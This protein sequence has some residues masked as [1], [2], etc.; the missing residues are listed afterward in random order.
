MA[1]K[2]TVETDVL[3]IGGGMAGCFAAI[4]ARDKGLDVTL[5]DKGYVSRA[6]QTPF[7]G[8]YAVYHPE[9][10][11]DLD[12]W[13]HQIN[14]VGEYVNNR[15]WTELV[16]KDSYDRFQDLVSWGVDFDKDDKGDVMRRTSPLGPCQ[17]IFMGW[18]KFAEI[19]RSQVLKAG[20]KIIDRL[21]I[22][23]LVKKDGCCVGAVGF[24]PEST[25]L[26]TFMAKA[27]ILSAGAGGFKAAGWP[28][29]ELT[30][31]ADV[32]AYRIGSEITGKE[33]SD[34]HPT[35]AE[36]PASFGAI[37]KGGR[38][39]FGK[40]LNAEGNEIKRMGTLFL[41][42]EFEAHAGR[43]PITQQSD[44]GTYTR[45]GGGASGMSV[46]KA[47][48]IWP[49]DA[50]CSTVIPGLYAAGDSLGTMQSGA[51]YASIGLA[52]CGASVTGARAGWA[53]AE[54]AAQTKEPEADEGEI[55]RLKRSLLTPIERK[56]GFSPRWVTQVLQNTMIPYYIMYIKHGD[57]MQAA[58]TLVEFIRDHLVP[59]LTAKDPH[60]LR[61]AHETKNMVLNAEMRLRSSIFRT[62]SRGCHYREDFPQRDDKNWLV[63]VKLKEEDGEM[64]VLKEPIPEEWQPDL[65]MPY[66]ERYPTRF[67]GE[68]ETQSA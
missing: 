63:W 66:E 35:S 40:L 12:A 49:A 22:T 17:A 51:V 7:A 39:M 38:P 56:G 62:E 37:M 50:D 8:S 41:D 5:V 34:P 15:L 58:L 52:L 48:G 25:E 46:H 36:Y 24:Q 60:E 27:T 3:V 43:A 42:L 1:V 54:Y 26:H 19:L 59:K 44:L 55:Q 6:G 29:H 2:N 14:T 57:R 61:L 67:P 4:K 32:M 23:D 33:Y 16:F 64:K 21:M 18:R 10:G 47:E 31:D 65:S 11:H 45:I 9:W 20:A 13:M 30:A 68:M 53:A 28:I